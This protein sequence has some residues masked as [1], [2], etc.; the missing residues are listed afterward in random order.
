MPNEQ[1]SRTDSPTES[2]VP[3]HKGFTRFRNSA[4][5]SWKGLLAA[6]R[7]EEAFRLELFFTV[8][9]LPAALLLP[10]TRYERMA[11][12]ATLFIVFIVE[13]LNSG[14]ETVVDRVSYEKHELAGRAKDLASAAVFLSLLLWGYIWGSILIPM[15]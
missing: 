11:L 9:L 13:L 8:F 14:I 7:Y 3:N 15:I 10:V 4:Y 1:H 12:I 2:A 6:Y 5:Y